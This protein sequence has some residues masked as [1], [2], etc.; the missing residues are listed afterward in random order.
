MGTRRF[1]GLGRA[2]VAC[3]LA[4]LVACGASFDERLAGVD[5]QHRAGEWAASIPVLRELLTEQ[6]DDPETN[7]RL[8]LALLRSGQPTLAVWPLRRALDAPSEAVESGLL[9]AA[10]LVATGNGAAAVDA[11]DDVLRIEP[12]NARALE[13]RARAQ[14][15]ERNPKQAL[16]DAELL[17]EREPDHLGALDARATAL[18]AL[19]RNDEAE[20]ALVAVLERARAVDS[21]DAGGACAVHARFLAERLKDPA[22]AEEAFGA[23][24]AQ[25]PADVLGVREAVNFYVAQ[26]RPADALDVLRRAVAAAPDMLPFRVWLAERLY[27]VGASNEAD[28]LLAATTERLDDARAWRARAELE[29]RSGHPEQALASFERALERADEAERDSLRFSSADLLV[30]LGRLEQAEALGAELSTEVYRDLITGRILLARGDAAGAL[31]AFE[32][33]LALWPNNAGARYL[34]GRAAASLGDYERAMAEYLEAER[35]DPR[36]S[37]AAAELARIHL[38]FGRSGD[39]PLA[40]EF[41]RRHVWSHPADPTG[42]RLVAAAALEL[43]RFELARERLAVA[44]QLAGADPALRAQ[45][46]VE[47]AGVERAATGPDAAARVIEESGLDLTDAA[48]EPALRVLVDDL[49]AAGRS[50]DAEARIDALPESAYAHDVRARSLDRM[51]ADAAAV[52]AELERA[53][54]LDPGYAPALAGLA[55]LAVARGE[56]GAAI[57]LYDRAAEADD[58]SSDFAYAAAQLELAAGRDAAAEARLRVIVERH[59]DHAAA[60]NDLAWLLAEQG[61]DLDRALALARRAARLEPGPATWDTLGWVQFKRGD[62]EAARAALERAHDADP[63]LPGLAERLAQ[64]RSAAP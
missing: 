38:R 62:L 42:Y 30:D 15:A 55:L 24:L 17:L 34:A 39:A 22:R 14:L 6:P 16:E 1:R 47:R 45:V 8:G 49:I 35:A 28:A 9:L 12:L 31:A 51:G 23:C 40:L 13:L 36:A 50:A 27:G 3:A 64:V 52:R 46:V 48:A 60:C 43:E 63:A 29:R 61:R 56:S 25:Y 41:A 44:E 18:V 10:A 19:G 37:D 53:V 59:P 11:A 20:A 21:P 7:R 33:G 32:S 4:A 57:A 5:A 58:P 26:E 54:E 2:L